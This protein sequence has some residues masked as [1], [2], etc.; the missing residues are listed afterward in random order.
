MMVRMMMMTIMINAVMII[1]AVGKQVCCHNRSSS[2]SG[3]EPLLSFGETLVE[4][5][6]VK[7]KGGFGR[8][9]ANVPQCRGNTCF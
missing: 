1:V 2:K 3:I 8:G 6:H 4:Y 7:N 5:E 9:A